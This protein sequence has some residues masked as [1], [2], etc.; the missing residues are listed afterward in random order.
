M[1]A[2]SHLQPHRAALPGA[3]ERDLGNLGQF[4]CWWQ[5]QE[6]CNALV[7]LPVP[8][9][10]PLEVCGVPWGRSKPEPGHSRCPLPAGTA[11][12]PDFSCFKQCGSCD[13]LCSW[14]PRGPAG[15]T[16]YVL[17]LW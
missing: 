1:W 15:N 7:S 3:G 11:E 17:V 9:W 5:E 13:F 14:P 10:H 16:T 6:H 2:R 8:L 4:P 12:P